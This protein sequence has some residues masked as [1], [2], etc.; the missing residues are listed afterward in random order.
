MAIVTER[1]FK[2]GLQQGCLTY[3][4]GTFLIAAADLERLCS[5][6]QPGSINPS[7]LFEKNTT[8]AV[9][10]APVSTCVWVIHKHDIPVI[11][12]V[13]IF[14]TYVACLSHVAGQPVTRVI[15]MASGSASNPLIFC[16]SIFSALG[17]NAPL[18]L[19]LDIQQVVLSGHRTA[20]QC[21]SNHKPHG[22]VFSEYCSLIGQAFGPRFLLL[23]PQHL[24]R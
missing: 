18:P 2:G 14:I 15:C 4:K 16:S 19:A 11:R 20:R 12:S 24:H 5:F 6:S 1:V 8:F 7:P 22:V 3:K 23:E 10:K 17:E 13:K 9:Y 21:S